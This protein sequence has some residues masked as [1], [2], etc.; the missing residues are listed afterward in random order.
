M[1]RTG[2]TSFLLLYILEAVDDL[3]KISII[4]FFF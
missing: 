2:S 1:P 4:V 3:V